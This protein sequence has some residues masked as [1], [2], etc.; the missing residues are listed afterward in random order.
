MKQQ[1][2]P[3][4][5]ARTCSWPD[6]RWSTSDRPE[7]PT[8]HQDT[9]EARVFG[10][11]KNRTETHQLMRRTNWMLTVMLRANAEGRHQHPDSPQ[12][13]ELL[14]WSR[15]SGERRKQICS[16]K[17][18]EG[19]KTCTYREYSTKW[20]NSGSND[21]NNMDVD[22]AV[23]ATSPWIWTLVCFSQPWLSLNRRDSERR[24][25]CPSQLFLGNKNTWISTK[26]LFISYLW[27]SR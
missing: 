5:E 15:S 14:P 1:S 22:L 8:G 18:L 6:P 19:M 24:R 17:C 9:D 25:W 21:Q 11:T 10:Q 3:V 4:W 12:R 27:R 20:W 2:I 26:K 13:W 7:Q 23:I 16:W